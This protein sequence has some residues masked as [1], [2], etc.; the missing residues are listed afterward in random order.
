MK[1]KLKICSLNRTLTLWVMSIQ[2]TAHLENQL[3]KSFGLLLNTWIIHI[4]FYHIRL[5]GLGGKGLG[6]HT[7][8]TV[9]FSQ[10]RNLISSIGENVV[11]FNLD[12]PNA[13]WNM[14]FHFF[15]WEKLKRKKNKKSKA[16]WG[17]KVFFGLHPYLTPPYW[18]HSYFWG[19]IKIG[20][21]K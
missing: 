8:W 4:K 12:T 7:S 9:C 11:C 20:T 3:F 5:Q 2:H 6:A 19:S 13:G 17:K 16:K 1:H 21:I 10:I 15:A 18:A 14:L